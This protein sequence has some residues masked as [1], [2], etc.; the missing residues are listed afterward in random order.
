MWEFKKNGKETILYSEIYYNY[1]VYRTNT[2]QEPEPVVA[3]GLMELNLNKTVI[4]QI[5]LFQS[6]IRMYM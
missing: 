4:F 2:N 5:E 1:N 3:Y 6:D